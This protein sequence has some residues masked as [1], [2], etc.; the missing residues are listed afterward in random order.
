VLALHS[1]FGD[2]R[3][4]PVNCRAFTEPIFR[5]ARH[6]GLLMHVATH[7][8]QDCIIPCHR[9]ID[10]HPTHHPLYI[11]KGFTT[12]E[13]EDAVPRRKNFQ[14][15]FKQKP[16]GTVSSRFCNTLSL[17]LHQPIML[18]FD[19]R[20]NRHDAGQFSNMKPLLL[21]HSP[22][23]VQNA[24]SSCRFLLMMLWCVRSE[25]RVL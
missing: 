3:I 5:V 13:E 24:H 2:R 10:P 18:I 16:G 17:S 25:G 8:T 7:S 12:V 4:A 15:P 22:T 11:S 21:S 9:T 23:D 6:L 14:G 20:H 1:Q 19:K